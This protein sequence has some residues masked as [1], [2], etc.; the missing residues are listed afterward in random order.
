MNFPLEKLHLDF[1]N[2]IESLVQPLA[3]VTLGH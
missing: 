3:S 1:F 2:Q